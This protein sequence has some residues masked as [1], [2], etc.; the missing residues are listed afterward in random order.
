ML[1][2]GQRLNKV[3][4]DYAVFERP[5]GNIVLHLNPVLNEEDFEKICPLPKV[6]NRK[7]K[8]GV[9]VPNPEDK[10]YKAQLQSYAEQ[11]WAWMVL[12]TIKDTPELVFETVNLN[13]PNTW[14]NY[15]KEFKEAGFTDYELSYLIKRV[16]QANAL[17]EEK[18]EDARKAFLLTLSPE[19]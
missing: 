14:P 2:K 16:I 18:L 19:E 1:L 13:D 8:G 4:T 7:G 6:P 17:S 9:D 3:R 15:Q 5:G 12:Q 11:K 10:N